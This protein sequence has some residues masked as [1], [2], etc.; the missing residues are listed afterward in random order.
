M[1]TITRVEAAPVVKLTTGL[2]VANFSSAHA[3]TFDDGTVLP[4]CSKERSDLLSLPQDNFEREWEGP[5]SMDTGL[6]REARKLRAVVPRFKL[7]QH[8][9]EELEQIEVYGD[10]EVILIPFPMLQAL[11]DADLLRK[12][13]KVGTVIMTDRVAKKASCWEF[14]RL[15]Y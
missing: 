5:I 15:E 7:S 2:R 1:A 8:L 11:K 9:L 6:G 14:G 10:V 4:A 12:F 13:R 3:F